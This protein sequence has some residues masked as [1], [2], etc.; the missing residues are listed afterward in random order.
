MPS[1]PITNVGHP[2]NSR[3][4]DGRK[5]LI[6]LD[7]FPGGILYFAEWCRLIPLSSLP[8]LVSIMQENFQYKRRGGS[9]LAFPPIQHWPGKTLGGITFLSRL[10]SSSLACASVTITSC[11]LNHLWL[12]NYEFLNSICWRWRI[13]EYW[14][15]TTQCQL[16]RGHSTLPSPP[17]FLLPKRK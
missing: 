1:N 5:L 9:E 4:E 2:I 10:S 15:K 14:H 7:P 3:M 13:F 11:H 16:V 12:I 6:L 17:S 8:F